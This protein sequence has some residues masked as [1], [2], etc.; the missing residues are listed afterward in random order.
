MAGSAWALVATSASPTLIVCMMASVGVVLAKRV[1]A[2]AGLPA[3]AGCGLCAAAAPTAASRHP[4]PTQKGA[5]LGR[6]ACSRGCGLCAAAAPTAAS[7]DPFPTRQGVLTPAGCQLLA[8]VCFLVFTPALTFTKLAQAVSLESIRHLWPLLANMFCSIC[9]GL[10][11]GLAACRLLRAPR[12]FRAHTLVSVA[13]GNV[14]QVSARVAALHAGMQGAHVCSRWLR[15]LQ[16][17]CSSHPLPA[18]QLPL[19]FTAALCHDRDAVFYQTLGK[20]GSRAEELTLPRP[21]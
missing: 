20:A 17:M 10:A 21:D 18:P 6:P 5:C 7:R 3:A 2:W 15:Q 14:G 4:F 16:H 12:E 13:F 8:R 19:V 1:R 9:V 11:L